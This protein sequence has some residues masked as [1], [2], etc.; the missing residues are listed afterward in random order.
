MSDLGLRRSKST[1]SN[2]IWRNLISKMNMRKVFQKKQVWLKQPKSKPKQISCQNWDQQ[3]SKKES[4]LK[5][6]R[7]ERSNLRWVELEKRIAALT[8]RLRRRAV[9]EMRTVGWERKGNTRI[10]KVETRIQKG[11]A[12]IFYSGVKKVRNRE[13]VNKVCKSKRCLWDVWSL[14]RLLDP[15]SF[16]LTLLFSP[17]LSAFAG[18][19]WPNFSIFMICHVIICYS[20][21]NLSRPNGGQ[22]G[23]WFDLFRSG[24]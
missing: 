8:F 4:K 6:D 21:W 20:R 18:R 16:S 10:T 2:H 13:K 7:I 1:L 19:R 9:K 17:P 14:V 3:D 23:L 5:Q 24:K 12:S 15:F 11:L 22:V